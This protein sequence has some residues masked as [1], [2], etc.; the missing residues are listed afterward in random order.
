[1]NQFETLIKS[2]AESI[3]ALHAKVHET[4]KNRNNNIENWK[5][6]C[7]EFRSY[8][9]KMDPLMEQ[10]YAKEKYVD[11]DL[12]EFAICFMQV[13]PMFFRSG[14]AK[15]V[16]LKKLKRS[17]FS[18]LQAEKLRQILI[19]AVKNRGTREYRRYCRLAPVVLNTW[20]YDTLKHFAHG[21]VG[22]IRSRAELMLTYLNYS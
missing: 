19:D 16:I 10:I 5:K 20:F 13:N 21:N 9:S 6:A 12:L 17:K 15:E 7:N 2:E 8:S 14:Y 1:M 3:S 4:F 11:Q 18:E 22:A